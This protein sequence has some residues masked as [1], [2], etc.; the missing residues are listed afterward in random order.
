[1]DSNY[2]HLLKIVIIGNTS[3]GKSAILRRFCDDSYL[4]TH[5]S[6][7]GVDFRVKTINMNE[8]ILIP[9]KLQ[10]WDTSGQ[11]RFKTITS[12]YYRGS[13]GIIVVY[14]ITDRESFNDVNRW[15]SELK[16][17]VSD[18]S[19]LILVGSKKDLSYKRV[20]SYEEGQKFA[21]S[22]GISFIEVSSFKNFNIDKIFN[23]LVNDID[24]GLNFTSR[25]LSN[26]HIRLNQQ[27]NSKIN[28]PCCAFN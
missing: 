7:I 6:T 10:I 23:Q 1:M 14:D 17:I 11:E 25:T 2:E 24:K 12:S 18:K 15:I 3:V 4:D 9:V 22:Y 8:N 20:I 27:K 21:D 5:V 13:H 19:V 28:P 26:R 16:K